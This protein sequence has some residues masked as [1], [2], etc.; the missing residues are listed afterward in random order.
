M[1]CEYDF[2][3]HLSDKVGKLYVKCDSAHAQN[4]FKGGKSHFYVR[5]IHILPLSNSYTKQDIC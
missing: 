1:R 5:L 3:H 2:Y 4:I